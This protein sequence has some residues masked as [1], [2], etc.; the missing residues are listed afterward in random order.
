MGMSSYLFALF[1]A[2]AF[3]LGSVLQQRG[4]LETK[5]SEGD[6]HFLVEILKNPVWLLG[7]A[8]Q[9]TGWILQG[10]ALVEGSLIVVQYICALSLVFAL[11]LGVQLSGQHIG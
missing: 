5:A 11:P 3:T 10:A 9:V 6:P 1:A 2:L 8:L 4:T 7:G